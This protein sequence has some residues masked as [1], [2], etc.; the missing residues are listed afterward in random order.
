MYILYIICNIQIYNIYINIYIFIINIY[1]YI[2]IYIYI[3][4]RILNKKNLKNTITK[5]VKINVTGIQ[6]KKA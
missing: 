5:Y 6:I 4:L 3:H 1:I 2:F